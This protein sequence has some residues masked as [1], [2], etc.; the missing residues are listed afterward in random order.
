MFPQ[1]YTVT[2]RRLYNW[3][4]GSDRRLQSLLDRYR[5]E[6]V[7]LLATQADTIKA[8]WI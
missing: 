4:D 3:L 6:G 8:S 7:R 2:G 1:D 5:W